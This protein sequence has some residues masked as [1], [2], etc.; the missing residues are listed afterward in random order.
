[1]YPEDLETEFVEKIIQYK[2][3]ISNLPEDMKNMQDM[4][5]YLN[6]LSFNM[7]LLFKFSLKCLFV[8]HA[9]T[10]VTKD[11]YTWLKIIYAYL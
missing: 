9:L 6:T 11:L 4:L 1:M 2:K 10:R 5:K 8:W 3:H 7:T